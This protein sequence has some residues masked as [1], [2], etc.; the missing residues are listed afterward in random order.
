MH[1]QDS[2]RKL[3]GIPR[4]RKRPARDKNA[5][6]TP[7]A[8][9]PSSVA[10][11][12]P[13]EFRS[14][15]GFGNNLAHP[16]WGTTD[17]VYLRL[18]PASYADLIGS[19]SGSERPNARTISNA[20]CAQEQ[21]RPNQRGASDYLWQW[22]QFLD[23][24][25]DETPT[26]DPPETFDI[27][28]PAGDAWF[29]PSG[30][31]SQT[32]PLNRSY[33]EMING[34]R[35]QVNAITAYIDASNIYGSDEERAF[36]L[37]RLDGSGLLKTSPSDRGDLLPYN[38]GGFDNA[39]GPGPSLFLAGDVRANEQ[40]ALTAMHTLFM[41]EHNHWAR[42]YANRNPNSTGE[43]IYQFA[44]MIVAGELQAITYREFLPLLLGP[45]AI[46]P[47]QGYRPEVNAGISNLFATAA[48][49]FGH[50]LLSPT[51]LRID[52]TRAEVAAGHLALA[53]AFFTPAHLE[54]EGIDSLLRGLAAQACQELD[55][56]LVDDVRNFLF[57]PP[58]SG[59]F[60]LAALNMQRGRDHGLPSF[61]TACRELGQRPPRE[62]RDIHPDPEVWKRLETVYGQ[63]D[64]VDC[65]VGGLCER[66]V[67]EAM[68]G[69][70]LHRVLSDQFLRLRDGDRFYYRS[71]LPQDL[72]ALVEDQ[73]LARIIRRN[74]RIGPELA[75][76]VFLLPGHLQPKGSLASQPRKRH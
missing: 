57:G 62:F 29:D 46:P 67:P 54:D 39:G 50:S 5:T 75:E 52:S 40:A 22:G 66:P 71:Y 28:I 16:T 38:T 32:I 51:L 47:Y 12:F 48:Y 43:E 42:E 45:E 34:V 4:S 68:V 8:P 36:A 61:T 49:R 53:D 60:D 27:E 69:P 64:R 56:Q 19:P 10:I 2:A 7:A 58:G 14:I 11:P 41:R 9:A 25:L 15:N 70:M 65:W 35:Q 26:L 59:G 74:T 31:G 18:V 1:T 17:Q 3:I 44:R 21:S 73:T 55:G 72:I 76:N 30:S 13:S 20:V 24:D 23:H 63:V 37:R 33:Y 6:L